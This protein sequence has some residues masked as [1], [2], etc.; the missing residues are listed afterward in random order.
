MSTLLDAEDRD[1]CWLLPTSSPP[2][3][4]VACTGTAGETS[5]WELCPFPGRLQI[6]VGGGTLD[7]QVRETIGPG[8]PI[9]VRAPL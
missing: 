5:E 8:G 1:L 3:V 2:T 6:A 4:D 9:A 7:G